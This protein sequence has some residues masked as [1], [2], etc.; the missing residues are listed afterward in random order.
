MPSVP[1]NDPWLAVST[2][3]GRVIR[4][5]TVQ[6][7]RYTPGNL[8]GSRFEELDNVRPLTIQTQIGIDP[9]SALLVYHFGSSD[10]NAPQ[11]AQEALSTASVL[12]KV[13][14]VGD[15]LVVRA[16]RPDGQ[17]EFLF[18]GEPVSFRMI[19]QDETEA[20]LIA[21]RGIARKAWETP[22]GG[23]LFR[24]AARWTDT[25][26]NV[27]TDVVLQ[28]NPKG[29]KNATKAGYDVDE[30]GVEPYPATMDHLVKR[31]DDVRAYWTISSAVRHLL[32]RFNK[33]KEYL[34]NPPFDAI[35]S[36]LHSKTPIPGIP[37][38]VNNPG[39]YTSSPIYAKDRPLTGRDW[40]TAIMEMIR[41]YGFGMTFN[42]TTVSGVE[43]TPKYQI[44]F[45]ANQGGPQKV[46][47]LQARGSQLDPN[48]SN[49][50]E[51]DLGRD[52]E[53]VANKWTVIGGLERFQASFVLAPGFGCQESDVST[54]GRINDLD[55]SNPDA[56][57]KFRLWVFDE[58]GEGHY[59]NGSN[60]RLTL[61][62]SLLFLMGTDADDE[63]VPVA[64]R[65]RPPLGDLLTLDE[66][67]L[68]MRPALYISKD[69]TGPYPGLWDGTG[70]WQ[71]AAMGGYKIL[72]DRI[73]IRI[74]THNPNNFNVG[75]TTLDGSPYRLG[76]V[77]IAEAMARPRIG[78][79]EFFFRLE[80]VIEGDRSV[81]GV[82]E[83]TDSSI[84][85]DVIERH[86]DARDRYNLDFIGRQS[87]HNDIDERFIHKD[88]RE[89]AQNEAET[90]RASSESGILEGEVFIPWITAY[91]KVGDLI[92]ELNGRNLGFRTDSGT[93]DQQ[94]VYPMVEG[95]RWTFSPEVGTF[96]RLSDESQARHQVE[97]RLRKNQPGRRVGRG[98]GQGWGEG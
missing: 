7:L 17:H 75:P 39:T 69:Y 70:T 66:D 9:G 60:T 80:C 72:K 97:R 28:F 67:N 34:E 31:T 5:I 63:D 29:E 33:N 11:N 92:T 88:D 79:P 35:G 49:T 40:P 27:E 48:F 65:R 84:V 95:I 8:P 78:T 55:S 85:P 18:Y 25:G 13:V 81:K 74:T 68:P 42:L 71:L 26:G 45:F 61:E 50:A 32:G 58:T 38:D 87:Q 16:T 3:V 82:A 41:D 83:R 22:I 77:Y 52:I 4:P 53:Q 19:L 30:G 15:R 1:V 23:T 57:D 36:V 10:S 12:P 44:V 46:L 91:Y 24:D 94:P 37:F 93:G 51:A 43:A 21:C 6:V 89:A 2:P 59:A 64:T 56:V 73:G 90:Y 54:T 20:V 76:V 86:V 14:Q 62:T 98:R 47:W 96:L